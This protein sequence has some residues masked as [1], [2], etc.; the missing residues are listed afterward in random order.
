MFPGQVLA[1]TGAAGGDGGYIV[2]LAKADGLTVIADASEQDEAL[3][4]SLGA[5]MVVRSG[6]DVP[7]RI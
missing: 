7:S 4:T 5:D 2:Q 1:V 6:H 3:V